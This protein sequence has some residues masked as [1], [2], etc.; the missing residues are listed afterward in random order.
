MHILEQAHDMNSLYKAA[1]EYFT[2]TQDIKAAEVVKKENR[3]LLTTV[4]GE[5]V[6]GDL[7]ILFSSVSKEVQDNE[8]LEAFLATH[9]K[10]LGDFR[11]FQMQERLEVKKVK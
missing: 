6:V 10:S 5:R 2:A 1:H 3:P 8:A 4:T 9:G 7:K 11:K